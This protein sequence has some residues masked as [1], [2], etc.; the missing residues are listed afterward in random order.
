MEPPS[1]ICI[2]NSLIS[3]YRNCYDEE[4]GP[5]LLVIRDVHNRLFGAFASHGIEPGSHYFG[6][7]YTFLWRVGDE[8]LSVSRA[9]GNNAYY[10]LADKHELAF[11]GGGGF[12]LWMDEG[13]EKGH[14][15]DCDTFDPIESRWAGGFVVSDVEIWT[16]EN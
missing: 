8:G 5:F 4:G 11:G 10:V 16:F 13:L 9:S 15:G 2:S 3:R 7:G 1:Q 14:L 6:N 12:G